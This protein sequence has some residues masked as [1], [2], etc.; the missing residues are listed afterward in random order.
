MALEMIRDATASGIQ[1]RWVTGDRVYG[2]YRAI[3]MWLEE[4]RKSYVMCVSGKEYVWDGYKQ[5]SIGS[6]LKNLPDEGWFEA[7]RGDGSKGARVYDMIG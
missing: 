1:Y 7:S 6:I 2:D 3:R 4:N 5:V